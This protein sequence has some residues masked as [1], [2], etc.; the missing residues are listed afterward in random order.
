MKQLFVFYDQNCGLCSKVKAWVALQPQFIPM[1][2]VAYQNPRALQLCP[3]LP[4]LDPSREIVILADTGAVYT[5]GA[6]WIICLYALHKYRNWSK[7]MANPALLPL[8]KRTCH[9][10]SENRLNISHLLLLKSDTALA[11]AITTDN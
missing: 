7:R 10:I 1:T 6:A 11:N 8:A 3:T 9:L 4:E 2:F 5:G